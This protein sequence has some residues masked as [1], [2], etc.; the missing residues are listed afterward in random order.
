VPRNPLRRHDRDG[1]RIGERAT[2][3]GSDIVPGSGIVV[4]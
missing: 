4:E 1:H 2:S 3:P